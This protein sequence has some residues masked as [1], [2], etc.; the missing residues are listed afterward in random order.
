M[1]LKVGSTN[2]LVFGLRRVKMRR[3][4]L[5]HTVF[6]CY[7]KSTTATR[8]GGSYQDRYPK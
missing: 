3:H 6:V 7:D 8:V 5:E 2:L 4:N 1:S